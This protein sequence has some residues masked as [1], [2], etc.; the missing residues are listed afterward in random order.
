MNPVTI[1]RFDDYF[2]RLHGR[3]P[4][5]W[6]RRLAA[7][8]VNGDWPG[9]IDLP[10]GSGKTACLD[11]ALFA[12]ACQASR[13][14][15]ERAAPR[16][17]FF[18]VNRRIIVDEAYHRARRIAHAIWAAERNG[19]G[20]LADVA[21][22]LRSIAG[23]GDRVDIPPVDVLE[24]RGG[25][26]RDNRW[27]RSLTQ[28][29]VVCTTL[30][31]LGSRL[32][33]RG[34]GLSP[35]AAPIHAALI[36]YDSLILLDEAHISEPFRQTLAFV[37]RYLAPE[38]WTERPIG[39]RPLTVVPM[40]AT[41]PTDLAAERIIR[42][43]DDDR[44]VAALSNR[45]TASK[46]AELRLVQDV[47]EAI[48]RAVSELSGDHPVAIGIIVNRVATA[49]AI[50]EMLREQQ[51]AGD[52][53]QTV[54]ADASIELVIASMRPLDRD[55]Q[56]ERLRPLVGPAR[57]TRS[58]R[59][60]FVV[61]T[62]C[63]E[64]GA[65]FDFDV[66]ITECASLDAL[67]QRF[68]RL[69]RSGRDVPVRAVIVADR[70][71][72]KPDDKLD[73][74]K[75]L[76]PI[77]GNALARTWNWLSERAS[78]VTS[79]GKAIKQIDFG[80]DALEQLL[81]RDRPD[82]R[83]P[84]ELLA[85]SAS[86]DAPTMMPAY[87]DLWCQTAPRPVPDPD[88]S[89][90][91]H[92]AR[93]GEPDVQVC[94]RAD[95]VE[96]DRIE[97]DKHWCDIIAL[98][99]P[100]SAEC[101]TVPISRMRRWLKRET[102]G[103]DDTGD[104]HGESPRERDREDAQDR[105]AVRKAVLWRGSRKSKLLGSVG[106]LQ[107]GDTVVLP[108]GADASDLLGHLPELY[109]NS[110]VTSEDVTRQPQI[111]RDHAEVA[112]LRARARAT[113][114]LHP[115]LRDH[116]GPGFDDLLAAASSVGQEPL[117]HDEWR[118]RLAAAGEALPE[119]HELK[120]VVSHLAGSALHV[121]SYPDDCGVVLTS[122]ARVAIANDLFLPATDDGEDETS[123]IARRDYVSLHDHTRHV[124]DA[125]RASVAPLP[126]TVS[127]DV[128]V[129]AAE[130][131]DLGKAD[132][133][134]QAM[135]RRS[136]RTDAWLL[137]SVAS[138]LWAKSDG[139]PQSRAQGR[140]VQRRAGLPD[141]FRHEMLSVQ[142]AQH[143][144]E[145]P[146]DETVRDLVLHL[147]AAHHGHARP[148]APVVLDDELPSVAVDGVTLTHDQRRSLTPPHSLD[149]G[150]AERFWRLTRRY[151][152]WGLAY[153]ESVLRLAD[154]QASADEDAGRVSDAPVPELQEAAV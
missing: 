84:V 51:T 99:P 62:Q 90:F 93:D 101:M 141:G 91:I 54:P 136:D 12:L 38:A 29:T 114:R 117:L 106:E 85:P 86:L 56:V 9:A 5:P 142:V 115:V 121:E 118:V 57:P 52:G 73:D 137:A 95:L 123:R 112:F 18:C 126:L 59:T 25:I 111:V 153:L 102:R 34:Y 41:P 138:A 40:T 14:V 23:T 144:V 82:G 28:P 7:R 50:Y 58:E 35:S 45:L 24:L 98:L 146:E 135:L 43:E 16:R 132:E 78:E 104:L 36:A 151:G 10:T 27:T 129:R 4:Y 154:Q 105:G 110:P 128:F 15:N 68:G 108:A 74:D 116:L 124:T 152:W 96:S 26:Y 69:N 134:F 1:D 94:W 46:P 42:L 60:S 47:A 147:I 139:V 72:I 131:H 97:P 125:V 87:L 140:E 107:P 32:L 149:S 143:C 3:P 64:V 77:Y 66:L 71:S 113:L 130:L 75:P 109:A 44:Q 19:S 88:V 31:Q 83:P 70:K 80:I 33:F 21:A 2:E 92:G 37:A 48:V 63:L 133:R 13:P 145:L 148:F 76:D 100:T 103:E 17:I 79:D 6:Q 53:T 61:A 8:A 122:R 11:I 30:D 89:L 67:R 119:G 20:I 39:V 65:D 120:A 22:A 55:E 49:R 127:P 81:R 150:V